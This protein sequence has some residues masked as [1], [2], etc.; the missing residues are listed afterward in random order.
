MSYYVFSGAKCMCI[1]GSAQGLLSAGITDNNTGL[2]NNHIITVN[3]NPAMSGVCSIMQKPC[4]PAWTGNW[5]NIEL[6][7]TSACGNPVILNTA[8]KI[9][10]CGGIVKITDP[11]NTVVMNT[12]KPDVTID[13]NLKKVI[14]NQI[15]RYNH[16]T[17][18]EQ[19]KMS[20]KAYATALGT[21]GEAYKG[22][23]DENKRIM[24]KTVNTEQETPKKSK[25]SAKLYNPSEDG[26]CS[27]KCP[28]EYADTCTLKK[29]VPSDRIL[30][31]NENNSGK[32]KENMHNNGLPPEDMETIAKTEKISA[33]LGDKVSCKEAYH[34]IIPGNECLNK[35]KYLVTLANLYGYDVNNPNN[36]VCLPMLKKIDKNITDEEWTKAKYD[37]IRGTGKQ[38][39]LGG[40]SFGSDMKGNTQYIREDALADGQNVAIPDYEATVS[41]DLEIIS[42]IQ[43]QKLSNS[44]RMNLSEEQKQKEKEDFQKLMD[45]TSQEIK[46]YILDYPTEKVN[47]NNY[48]VSRASLAYDMSRTK[49]FD[50]F[51]QLTNG[52]K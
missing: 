16:E 20:D 22:F 28:P 32:L 21:L 18:D 34:H 15:N 41:A 35:N 1:P 47:T 12:G 29:S 46:K 19:K 37:V 39:H 17:T 51:K 10:A 7:V 33:T 30:L 9:C 43:R 4:T 40:H 13:K 11:N 44:C 25:S 38:L 24:G 48:Y 5:I 14:E 50:E 8:I 27:G 31:D 26:I 6:C 49:S 2:N 23:E 45:N 42:Q 36:A 3:K 52:G